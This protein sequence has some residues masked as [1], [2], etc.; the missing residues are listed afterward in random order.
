LRNSFL[1][2]GTNVH[3]FEIIE[4]CTIDLLNTRE[5]YWQE[6]Y[7]CISKNGLNCILT[8]TKDCKK[9][10][11]AETKINMSN[12]CLK[13]VKEGRNNPPPPPMKGSA[14]P[15]FGKNHSLETRLKMKNNKIIKKGKDHHNSSIFLDPDTGVY[16]FSVREVAEVLNKSYDYVA[17][18]LYG[19]VLK[20][21][22]K[23]IK[24]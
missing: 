21:N 16:Y 8:Q 1:K 5:R 9:V 12:A 20:N 17:D 23:I 10:T 15:M 3:V 22:L 24:V 2:Y 19:K 13:R 11:S 14:N 6:F 4:E 18:R 7:N